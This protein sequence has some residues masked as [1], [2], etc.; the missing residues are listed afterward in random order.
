MFADF[1]TLPELESITAEP[2]EFFQTDPVHLV[3]LPP[4]LHL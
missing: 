1:L 4:S 3:R 2:A